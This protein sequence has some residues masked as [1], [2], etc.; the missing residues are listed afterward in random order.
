M[1]KVI[2]SV[3]FA[4]SSAITS[5]SHMRHG[6]R[7]CYAKTTHFNAPSVDL[8]TLLDKVHY[9]NIVENTGINRIIALEHST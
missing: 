4:I 8:E 6:N 1:T 3:L 2:A 5:H 9:K 7:Q